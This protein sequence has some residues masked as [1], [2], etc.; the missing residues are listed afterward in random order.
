ML[1]E[2]SVP[3]ISVVIVT[4]DNFTTIRKTIEYLRNQTAKNQ[5]EIVIVA[6][7]KAH[8]NLERSALD[9]FTS[10]KVV[11]VGNLESVAWG[12]A[13]GIRQATAP[14]VVLAEDHSYPDPTWGEALIRAHRLSWAAVGPVV[15]NANPESAL[16][17][18]DFLTGYGPWID[19]TPAGVATHLPGHNCSYKRAILIEYGNKLESLLQAESVLH[20]DL[21]SR[22]FEIYLEPEAK[23]SHTNFSKLSSWIPVHFLSGRVFAAAR[24]KNWPLFKRIIYIAGA[25]LIPVIRLCR[26]ISEMLKPG[27]LQNMSLSMKIR[28]LLLLVLGLVINGAGE[29]IGYTIGPGHSKEKLSSY[30]FYRYRHLSEK[31]KITIS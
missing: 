23:I 18:A 27:R 2:F 15:K 4:P 10:V 8:L 19:P 6:P 26:S 11:E 13:T 14:V 28:I 7:S 25:P 31:D 3:L 16:S 20:W 17:W 24:S 9:D 1:N 29:L 30:E 5:M 12:N 22:G 21:R